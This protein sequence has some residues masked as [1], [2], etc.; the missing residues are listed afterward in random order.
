MEITFS[1]PTFLLFLISIPMLIISHIFTVRYLERRAVR[2]A[3]FEAIRRVTGGDRASIKNSILLTRNTPL[4][5]MRLVSLTMLIF[6]AAGTSLWMYG[7]ANN[8]NYVISIDA[9]SSMLADDFSP[10]RLAAAKLA[11]S[12]FVQTLPGRSSIGVLSFSGIPFIEQQPTTDKGKVLTAIERIKVRDAGGTDIAS[13]IITGVNM[14]MPQDTRA[15]ILL[16]DGRSTV[17]VPLQE[18][19]DYAVANHAVVNAIGVATL[20]GGHYLQGSEV[21]ILDE[22]SLQQ[23]SQITGGKYLRAEN[24]TAIAESLGSIASTAQ[25]YYSVDLS[26]GLLLLSIGV[27]FI[28]WGLV[29]TRFKTIP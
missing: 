8:Y 15:L 10:T 18:G 1:N 19:V 7:T 4:L 3:N 17:G 9:S 29:T 24:P 26:G 20:E 11:A 25:G 2:F 6:A 22:Q 21:S 13:A 16:T 27:L 5:I 12:E 23:V 28:E 14:L